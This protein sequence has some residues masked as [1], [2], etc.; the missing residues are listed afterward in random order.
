MPLESATYVDELNSS[1][2]AA[3][4]GLAQADDHMRL[5]KAVLLASFPGISGAADVTDVQLTDLGDGRVEFAAGGATTPSMTFSAEDTLGWYRS[6]AGI[7]SLSTGSR[8]TGNGLVPA[9]AVVSFLGEPDGFGNDGAADYEWLE[10]NGEEYTTS[11]YAALAAHLGE[12][13]ATF[14]LPDMTDTGRFLR[15]RHTGVDA[16]DT[17]A[18]A[19]KSHTHDVTGTAAS[20]GAHSH[21]IS[22]T[23]PGHTHF[24]L[25]NTQVALGSAPTASNQVARSYVADTFNSYTTIGSA[26]AATVG[27]SSSEETG[28]T[29]SSNSTGAHT[30]DTTGTAAAHS[31]AETETRPEALAVIM[32]IKT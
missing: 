29:A 12:V 13:G 17:Q 9:G 6:A 23:D 18:N 26:T 24:T 30:H 28:V 1:N 32:C 4:D 22:I 5:L 27:L 14:T 2:P 25:A 16:G 20:G 21:T 19:I 3:A 8:V 11:D 7:M 10:L 31:G 15:S